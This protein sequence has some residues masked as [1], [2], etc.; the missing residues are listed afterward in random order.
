MKL[1]ENEE[2]FRQAIQFTAQDIGIPEIFIEK[3]YWVTFALFSIFKSKIGDDAVFK[4]G[5]SLLKCFGAIKRF[6]EDID[7]VVLRREGESNNRLNAKIKMIGD[8]VSNVLPEVDL[9]NVTVKMGMNRKTAHEYKKK[10]AGDYGH[11]RDKIIIEATWLGY[12]EPYAEMPITSFVYEMMV[13]GG[14][15]ELI[16]EYDLFPFMGKVLL[17]TRT[18]CEKIMSL[19]RFSYGTQPLE[20][21][22]LKV[23]HA[24]DLHQLLQVTEFLNYFNSED[25][26]EMLIK[27]GHDDMVSYKTNHQWLRFHPNESLIFKEPAIPWEYMRAV[28]DHQFRAMVFGNDFPEAEDILQTLQKIKQRLSTVRWDVIAA[29]F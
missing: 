12:F 2:L 20:D 8:A 1:H 21:L 17:P 16:K 22:K 27:V 13:R 29:Q 25:F 14:Q 3:D 10:F 26:N 23:R 7:L 18:I 19:V 15:H 24:Y 9:P 4:G 11:V 5:T 6:S 28:Y